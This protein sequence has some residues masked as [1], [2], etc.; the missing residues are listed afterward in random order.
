MDSRTAGILQCCGFG[1]LIP[2]PNFFHHGSRITGSEF[3]PEWWIDPGSASK[4]LN[5]LITNI[6]SKLS[7]IRSGLFIPD[8]GPGS[9]FFTHPR[10]RGQKGTDPGSGSATVA[11]STNKKDGSSSRDAFNN[12]DAIMSRKVATEGSPARQQLTKLNKFLHSLP[13]YICKKTKDTIYKKVPI[14]KLTK[15][16][17]LGIQINVHSV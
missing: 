17:V 10:S 8:P 12:I 13:L 7:E 1:M 6:V 5:I 16:E 14:A 11:G 4:N 3:Y 9:W 2:D 15:A